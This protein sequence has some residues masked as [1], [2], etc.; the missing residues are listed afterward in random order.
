M[1]Y[2]DGLRGG[3]PWILKWIANPPSLQPGTK[4]PSFY[5]G[6]PD[7]ILKGNQDDQIRALRDYIFWFGTHPGQ[8]LPAQAGTVSE[9]V[10]NK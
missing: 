3:R 10:S 4:M 2:S 8:T 5:P 9:K 6:G 7:D 1:M